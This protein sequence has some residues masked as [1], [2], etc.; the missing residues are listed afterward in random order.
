ME[1]QAV[2]IPINSFFLSEH[3]KCFIL[4]NFTCFNRHFHCNV[5]AVT[6]QLLMDHIGRTIFLICRALKIAAKGKMFLFVC[7]FHQ[8][9]FSDFRD[10]SL[11]LTKLKKKKKVQLVDL[12]QGR[13]QTEE[14]NIKPFLDLHLLRNL[15][16]YIST[17]FYPTKYPMACL[18]YD[19]VFIFF[20]QLFI[21]LQYLGQV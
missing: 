8:K 18:S 2:Q 5:P 9:S 6:A 15:S 14:E 17:K 13:F 10:S 1:K 4:Q 21:F 11:L 3:H 19:I 7:Y 12:S 20:Y 16:H